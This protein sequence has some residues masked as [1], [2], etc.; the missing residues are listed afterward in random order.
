MNASAAS[1]TRMIAVRPTRTTSS[2]SAGSAA[3]SSPFSG[4]AAVQAE[5]EDWLAI[6]GE[7]STSVR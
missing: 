7:N 5:I 3:T 4:Q 6:C 2:T 1:A